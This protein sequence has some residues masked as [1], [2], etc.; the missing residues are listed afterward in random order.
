[1][2][3]EFSFT[4]CGEDL[5][6][7]EGREDFESFLDGFDGV[8]LMY[9]GADE[10]RVV[11]PARVVGVHL[12]YYPCWYDFWVGDEAALLDEFGS[13]DQV[14]RTYGSLDPKVLVDRVRSDMRVAH[15]Y[16]AEYVVYHVSESRSD[17]LFTS[18]FCHRDEDVV[19]A[20]AEILNEAFE[21]EDGSVALLM[22][23]LWQ[24]G[25]TFTRPDV[26]RRLLDAVAYPNRG[27][28]LDTGHLLH[29]NWDLTSQAEAASYVRETVDAHG[30]LARWVRGVHLNQSLTGDLMRRTACEPPRL[31]EDYQRRIGQ[32]FMH[33][34]AI[35]R[36]QP[37][38]DPT[39]DGLIERLEGLEWL[40][41]EL[42]TR[43]RGELRRFLDM[44]RDALP[45]TLLRT[46]HATESERA[47]WLP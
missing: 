21:G 18:R 45:R 22:E 44:Q 11:D 40:T 14:E 33:S 1:M 29:T 25:L 2:R 4:T 6:R 12:G 28:M 3:I 26:T 34:F 46:G 35:D 10:R 16:G 7:F 41:F 36:H 47:A 15:E 8:E 42:M 43:D 20:A 9:L 19:D 30:Q 17:E 13:L 31:E 24:S 37:F 23:N 38:C 27:I 32:L 5:D 39:L